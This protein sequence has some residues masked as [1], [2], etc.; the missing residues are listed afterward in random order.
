[1]ESA[2]RQMPDAVDAY[3]ALSDTRKKQIIYWLE[4]AKTEKTRQT[5]IDKIMEEIH[6]H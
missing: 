6:G 3:R 4:S 1:L 2:L 5:R